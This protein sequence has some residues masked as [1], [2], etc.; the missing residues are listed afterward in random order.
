[1]KGSSRSWARAG[2]LLAVILL[3][4]GIG[5]CSPTE[6]A[7]VELPVPAGD[8]IRL[9]VTGVDYFDPEILHSP[10]KLAFS[11]GTR[12]IW[13]ADLD[14]LTG[15]FLSADGK[16]LLVDVGQAPLSITNNGP[17]FAV[18]RHG[19]SI[20]YSKV[21][22]GAMQVWR[23]TLVAAG[24][25]TEPVTSGVPTFGAVA[26]RNSEAQT[27]YIAA[28]RG[29]WEQGAG[30]WL[31][32]DAPEAVHAF[33]SADRETTDGRW[34]DE[35]SLAVHTLSDGPNAGQLGMIDASTGASRVITDDTGQKTRPYG[36]I[37]PEANGGVRVLALV[38]TTALGIYEDRGGDTWTRVMTVGIPEGS[39]ATEIGSPEPFVAE[40]QS[41]ASVTL[42]D[43]SGLRRD[44]QIWIL[45]LSGSANDRSFRCDDG[46]SAPARRSDPETFFGSEQVFVYYYVYR[47][48]GDVELYRCATGLRTNAL[49]DIAQ[50]VEGSTETAG[51]VSR[52]IR[53]SQTDPVL[54]GW[55]E[56]HHVCTPSDPEN[57]DGRLF[58]FFPG[59]GATPG[60]YTLLT[61][62]AAHAGLHAIALRYPNDK[63]VNLQ[64]CPFSLDDD[65]HGKIR[66]ETLTGVDA[67]PLIDVD[68]ANSISG[69]LVRLLE[70]LSVEHPEEGWDRFLTTDG[71]I[72]WEHIVV[73]GHSQGAGHAAF[74]AYQH[75]V[76]HAVLFAWADVRRGEIAPWLRET[77]STTPASDYY[78]FWHAED[79]RVT[80]QADAL[81]AV[82]DLEQF[83]GSLVVDELQP[84]YGGS[85]SLIATATPPE[86]QRA[87]NVHVV[88]WALAL[89]STGEPLYRDVW[90]YL[91]TLDGCRESVAES[92][93]L[94]PQG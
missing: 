86:G 10:P 36:W 56:P 75:A 58:L 7:S 41:W 20:I 4:A 35:T 16:D 6:G 42:I 19:W 93:E 11:D 72:D 61:Q 46:L 40:G 23:A 28:I 49:T 43:E 44:G 21:T 59:T 34:V 84:P 87:H 3:G 94:L 60:D 25:A 74:V 53:P 12:A 31:D 13:L 14:P 39:S 70:S 29:S 57:S 73:S 38:D 52:E 85:H 83:G 81:I 8:C 76:D 27:S 92:T 47:F 67:S 33:S 32:L 71:A 64:L 65:C 66:A 82:L 30:V 2:V 24:F 88:D 17:E 55:D 63:S 37:A 90:R 69:R 45:D 48:Q 77:I 78:L 15:T 5:A 1:M 22:G 51:I 50:S 68:A 18:D 79:E 62:E 9:G 80:N 89:D 26:S 91:I 54:V